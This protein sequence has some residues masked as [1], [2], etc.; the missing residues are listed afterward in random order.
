MNMIQ[1]VEAFNLFLAVLF[2]VAYFY[3]LVYLVIGV[4]RRNHWTQS[5]DAKIHRYAAVISARNE[6]LSSGL[7]G[8]LCGGR[9]LHRQHR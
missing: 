2:T 9:Q 1:L 5:Q 8:H 4:I 6:A 7:P 3:Q